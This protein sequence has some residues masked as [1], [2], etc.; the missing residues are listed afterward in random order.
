[1]V[2]FC[3]KKE[4]IDFFIDIKY[5]KNTEEIYM[6]CKTFDKLQYSSFYK[7]QNLRDMDANFFDNKSLIDAFNLLCKYFKE[8]KLHIS[9]VTN[10][11]MIIEID[12]DIKP[13]WKFELLKNGQNN[14]IE[15]GMLIGGNTSIGN[16]NIFKRLEYN[17]N[18]QI[19]NVKIAQKIINQI[20]GEITNLNYLLKFLL[21]KEIA[22]KIKN[23]SIYQNFISKEIIWILEDIKKNKDSIEKRYPNDINILKYINYIKLL[24]FNNNFDLYSLIDQIC[25]MNQEPKNEIVNYWK[26]LSKY[27]E[28]NNEFDILRDLKN[29]HFDYSIISMN[30]IERDNPEEYIQKKKE[31]KNMKKIIL[32]HAI[33]IEPNS[34]K[35]NIKPKYIDKLIYDKGFYF[36]D[37]IDYISSLKYNGNIPNIG[38][39]FSLMACEIFYDQENLVKF[40]DKSLSKELNKDEFLKIQDKFEPNGLIIIE[41]YYTYDNEINI[42]DKN[43]G[44]ISNV[45]ILSKNYQIF[46]LYYFTLKRNEY[47]VLYRDPNFIGKNIYADFLLRI[48]KKSYQF[49]N[50]MN[51]YFEFSTEE[52]LKFLLKRKNQKVILITSISFDKSGKR[53]IEI[54]RKIYGFN[55][56]VL[57]FS[58]KKN[59]EENY[60]WIKDFQNCLY[61]TKSNL[62]IDYITKYN[63]AELKNLRKKDEE[64]NNF[65]LKD[66]SFDFIS[67]SHC[68]NDIQYCS[69]KYIKSFPYFRK[70][71]ILCPFKKLYLGMT[72]EG[73]VE[74]S[75]QACPWYITLFEYKITFFSLGFYL[76]INNEIDEIP[77]GLVYMKEWHFKNISDGCYYII[78]S[79]NN[80]EKK[81]LSM[82]DKEIIA[83]KKDPCENT[84]FKFFDVIDD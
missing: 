64:E 69:L 28:Y 24:D 12:K 16:N 42:K 19:L 6:Q 65:K 3:Y 62:Y 36:S 72:K 54:T 13:D 10:S 80:E 70:V 57:F 44:I 35:L 39:T 47:F 1:M 4:N 78:N 15:E 17:I 60:K 27:E 34:N 45:Y 66:F 75:E 81:Y 77:L 63:E 21:I 68:D 43:K 73:K 52:A 59:K 48:Q 37:S 41:N 49:T 18:E 5:L 30:I 2:Q 22:N 56:L 83:N 25:I 51:I 71:Y 31:C 38:E 11:K 61:T 20:N 50:N 40:K 46:P 76:N 74:K 29:C 23:F 7:L 79:K 53:F 32:Y 14:N 26:F 9:Q 58:S 84:K 33:E 55:L 67:Y 8:K 82:E